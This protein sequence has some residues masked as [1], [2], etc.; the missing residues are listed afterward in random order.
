MA[1]PDRHLLNGIARG[2]AAALEQLARHYA[3][4]VYRYLVRM[5]GDAT[6]AEDLAQDVAV[7]IWRALPGRRFPN[8]RALNA[9]VYTV[10]T[11]A[12]YMH[13]RKKRAPEIAWDADLDLPASE[14]CDPASAAERAEMAARVRKAVEALPEPE[15]RA[16]LLKAFADLRYPEI[17]EA[18]GEP[19]GTVKWRISRA[20]ER[21]R[22]ILT[23]DFPSVTRTVEKRDEPVQSPA[24]ISGQ[25]DEG[26]GALAHGAP[27][28]ELPRVFRAEGR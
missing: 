20:Y 26:T 4:P 27:R 5:C 23:P 12:Y 21:L 13:R 11:N 2:D 18:T 7:Q 22:R 1:E 19:V 24:G 15:R 14:E 3:A 25:R 10:A 16:L 8:G 28:P 17:A 6:L 9:W